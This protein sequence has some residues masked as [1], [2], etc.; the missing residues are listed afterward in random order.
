MCVNENINSNKWWNGVRRRSNSSLPLAKLKFDR[1]CSA[2]GIL[3]P[4][5]RV[6]ILEEFKTVTV[7]ILNNRQVMF[8][9]VSMCSN[10][11]FSF[12]TGSRYS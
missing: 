10:C 6:E 2:A 8:E 3:L 1:F 5:E 4:E 11:L 12:P 9:P 7:F